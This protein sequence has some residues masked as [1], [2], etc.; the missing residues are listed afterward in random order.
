MHRHLTTIATVCWQLMSLPASMLHELTHFVLAQ[1][2][3][4]QSAIIWDDQGLVHGVDWQP[5]TPRWAIVLASL[6][7]TIL[8]SLVGLVGLWRLL[9]APPAT[10]N[11]W[12]IAGAIAGWWT[13]YASP[14]PDDLDIYQPEQ[15]DPASN[16]NGD[17]S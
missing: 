11:E 14:S 6:G 16:S 7:P 10:L 17:P 9:T 13:I 8:G 2:W 3:A 4:E 12:L 15:S 5:E 1:P